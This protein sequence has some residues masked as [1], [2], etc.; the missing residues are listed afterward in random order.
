LA[1]R[2]SPSHFLPKRLSSWFLSRWAQ[3]SGLERLKIRVGLAE[4]MAP[5]ASARRPTHLA[6]RPDLDKGETER[7]ESRGRI[8]EKYG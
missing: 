6:A 1:A 2:L 4:G 7:G 5:S 3:R 8:Y